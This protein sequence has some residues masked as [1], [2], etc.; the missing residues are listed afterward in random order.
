MFTNLQSI[1]YKNHSEYLILTRAKLKTCKF[2]V[3]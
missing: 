1:K 3:L 2:E